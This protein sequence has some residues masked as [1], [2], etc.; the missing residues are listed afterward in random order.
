[1]DASLQAAS[2]TFDPA[3][4]FARLF[5]AEDRHFWFRSR[6]KVLAAVVCGLVKGLPPGYRV[7]EVGCGTGNVLRVLEA[8]CAGAEVTGMDLHEEGLAYARR[9]VRCR[10]VA[11]DVNASSFPE[12]FDLIGLFDVLEHLPDDSRILR[13]L[14]AALRPG[15]RLLLTVP[16]HQSLW[17]Y[18]DEYGGHYRRYSSGQLRAALEGAG[19]RVEHQTQFML[20]LYPFLKLARLRNGRQAARSPQ[21]KQEQTLRE[22]EPPGLLNALL[23]GLLR[24]EAW[25]VGRGGRLPLGTSLLAV[26]RKG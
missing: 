19:F 3:H 14:Y 11:G 9:R 24:W 10:V 17:S 23:Y 8:V 16:A 7:L 4:S 1:M 25:W 13:T 12:P 5:A 22:L 20:L 18:A 21:E 15:G 6:N 26:A 2:F